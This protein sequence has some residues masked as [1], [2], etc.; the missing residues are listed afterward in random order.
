MAQRVAQRKRRGKPAAVGAAR[1]RA[2]QR[3]V[4]ARLRAEIAGVVRQAVEHALE[5]E[6]TAVLGR[7]KY[8]RRATAPLRAAG[9]GCSRCRLDWAPRMFRAGSYRRTLVTTEACV[10]LRVPRRGCLCGGTVPLEFATF[11]RYERSWGD[12]QERARQLAGLCLALRDIREVLAGESG[13]WLAPSTLTRWV[14]G[15]AELAAMLRGEPF[16]RVPP[17]VLLDG[18]WVKLMVP[19]GERYRDQAGRERPRVRRGKLPLLVAYGVEPATGERWL[20]DWE[21]APGE[22]EASWR[23][24]LERLQARG[25]RAE[26]GLTLCVHDGSNGLEA[27]FGLVEFGPGVLR[28][29]CVFHVLRNVRDAVRGAPGMTREQKRARRREV[30]QAAATIW[31]PVDRAAVRQRYQAFGAR[32]RAAEPAAVAALERAFEATLAYLAARTRGRE[33]GEEWAVRYLRTTSA[34][35][36]VNRA[37]RQKARQVGTFQAERGLT[38]A[39]VLVLVHRGLAQA[40]PPTGLWTEVLE[41]GLLA[42]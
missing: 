3:Q 9:A 17:V 11:G 16:G 30:V 29:R 15:A 38:A 22:D 32:W 37:F 10:A 34:L 20:L 39:I 26:A 36:R 2:H 40:R 13:Q 4:R 21:P 8:Q 14:H 5:D 42:A 24:F 1:R 12:V 41:A 7:A 27:A 31:E 35:E 6:I 33:W 19:T 25:L 28:Q 18:V 23:G